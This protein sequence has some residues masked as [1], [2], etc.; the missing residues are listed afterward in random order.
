MTKN[1]VQTTELR[2]AQAS[3]IEGL[4]PSLSIRYDIYPSASLAQDFPL[5]L[6]HYDGL[7]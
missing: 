2:Q 7:Q 1:L 4:E 6:P 5:D 3:V